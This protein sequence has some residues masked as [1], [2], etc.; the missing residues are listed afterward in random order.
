M[1][2]NEKPDYKY[3]LKSSVSTPFGSWNAGDI[4]LESEWRRVAPNGE[5]LVD[6]DKNEAFVRIADFAWDFRMVL[7]KPR[8][9]YTRIAWENA[10]WYADRPEK[11]KQE[12]VMNLNPEHIA[13]LRDA[14]NEY[15][16]NA[17]GN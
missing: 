15:L 11:L 13:A 1:D 2:V 14:C 17:D 12:E 10:E 6:L 3:M 9:V 4:K 7:G 5:H 8:I 16:K